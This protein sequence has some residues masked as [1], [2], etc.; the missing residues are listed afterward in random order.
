MDAEWYTV[1]MSSAA[2]RR[3]RIRSIKKR[4]RSGGLHPWERR[5]VRNLIRLLMV[6]V[7]TWCIGGCHKD[8]FAPL[9]C[10][11]FDASKRGRSVIVPITVTR[12]S[13]NIDHV[14]M[15]GFYIR[16]RSKGGPAEQMR[17]YPP[18]AKLYLRVHV[19]HEVDGREIPIV[20]NDADFN[21]DTESHTFSYPPTMSERGTDV[22]Y[23]SSS[24]QLNGVA[25]REVVSF[26]FP[27]YGRYRVEVSTVSDMPILQA[28]PTWLTVEREFP[29]GK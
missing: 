12:A 5:A 24:G 11:P 9:A 7:L 10:V 25:H 6:V 26:R 8:S 22:A 3:G 23:V 27:D 17:G 1:T 19:F 28:I 2:P 14:Y 4:G 13:A 21:Y 20:V 16:D 29:H 18:K 15:V